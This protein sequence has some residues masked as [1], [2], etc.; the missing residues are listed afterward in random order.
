MLFFLPTNKHHQHRG[1]ALV[2]LY[3]AVETLQLTKCFKQTN[4]RLI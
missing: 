3:I 1:E 2:L 4:K